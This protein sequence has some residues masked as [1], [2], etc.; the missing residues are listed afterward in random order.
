[1]DVYSSI[2]EIDRLISKG[3]PHIYSKVTIDKN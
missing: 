1:M 2:K 3:M